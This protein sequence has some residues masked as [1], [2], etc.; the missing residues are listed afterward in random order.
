MLY[1][2]LLLAD[3]HPPTFP[4]LLYPHT[5]I[6]PAF[7]Y[8]SYSHLQSSHCGPQRVCVCVCAAHIS[9]VGLFCRLCCYFCN[10]PVPTHP[11]RSPRRSDELCCTVPH[12]T[13]VHHTPPPFAPT[14]FEYHSDRAFFVRVKIHGNHHTSL[15]LALPSLQ[16]Q[17]TQLELH[18]N[19]VVLLLKGIMQYKKCFLASLIILSSSFSRFSKFLSTT[20]TLHTARG[21]D[22]SRNTPVVFAQDTHFEMI[23]LLSCACRLQ[24]GGQ[25][26]TSA[27]AICYRRTRAAIGS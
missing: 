5:H 18:L 21:L 7:L 10:R 15:S 19:K 13:T 14:P 27:S 4:A 25:G 1:C 24:S 26:A 17:P 20:Q 6:L 16:T 2:V 22:R 9:F 8:V 11:Q 12:R 23:L 3:D